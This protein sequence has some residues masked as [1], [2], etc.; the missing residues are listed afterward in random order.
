MRKE[1]RGLS[2]LVPVKHSFLHVGISFLHIDNF[3]EKS[4]LVFLVTYLLFLKSSRDRNIDSKL[5]Y[6]GNKDSVN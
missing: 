1:N 3:E 4:Y 6:H 5:S 2:Y